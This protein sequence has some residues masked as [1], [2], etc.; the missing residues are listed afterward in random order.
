MAT[1]TQRLIRISYIDKDAGEVRTIDIGSRSLDLALANSKI[2]GLTLRENTTV[3]LYVNVD[4]ISLIEETAGK[5]KITLN[6]SLNE[7]IFEVNET[8]A[9]LTTAINATNAGTGAAAITIENAG[10]ALPTAA[11]VLDFVGDNVVVTGDGTTK[12]ITINPSAIDTSTEIGTIHTEV[13]DDNAIAN[14]YTDTSPNATFNVVASSGQLT[15]SGG[16]GS[17]ADYLQFTDST[18]AHRATTLENWVMRAEFTT[19][20]TLDASSFGF[21]MGV[22]SINTIDNNGAFIRLAQD[23]SAFE[24]RLDFRTVDNLALVQRAVLPAGTFDLIASTQYIFEVERN[25]QLLIGRLLDSTGA[26]THVEEFVRFGLKAVDNTFV[27]PNTGR[28]TIW[29]NGGTTTIQT[30]T[31]SSTARTGINALFVGDSLVSG[32]WQWDVANRYTN[33]VMSGSGRT[34]QVSAGTGDTLNELEAKIDE[35]RAYNARYVYISIGSNDEANG[36]V[37]A[38][39]ETD[40]GTFLT[41]LATGATNFTKYFLASPAARNGQTI[42]NPRD[43]IRTITEARA[44]SQFIDQFEATKANATDN[45]NGDFGAADNIHFTR[46]GAR[47]YAQVIRTEATELT[48]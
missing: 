23:T 39:W 19:G 21:S 38:Q 48:R 33:L 36:D 29:Q 45:I 31:I 11:E 44:D 35:I 5:A 12:T 22:R 16:D 15:L 43:R 18:N 47:V 4:R 37:D 10:S 34:F 3:K 46:E 1:L 25:G 8:I 42:T 14:R 2:I 41:N 30:L 40:Y 27:M 6:E 17:A 24:G 7:Q 28:F 32:L 9:E 26:T 13:W 20:A